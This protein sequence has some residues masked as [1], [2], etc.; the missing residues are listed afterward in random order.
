MNL[1]IGI[2]GTRGIPNHYGGFEQ[3]AEHLSVGLSQR[4]HHVSVYN[5][6]THPYQQENY[7]NVQIIHC[8]DPERLLGTAGQ[9]I[10]DL[11]CILDARKR[12]FDVILQLGYTSS[13][14]WGNL[15]PKKAINITNMDG[16]EWR[17]SKYT[18][19]VQKFLKYAESLAIKH[20]DFLIADSIEIQRY[21]QLK[22]KVNIQYI[23]YG[24]ELFN[25]T[26]EKVLA[27]YK[28]K[29][30]EFSLLMARMEPENNIE[31]I[32]EGV[33]HGNSEKKFVVIGDIAN[34]FGRYIVQKF[35]QDERIQFLGSLFN[36]HKLH[37][38][39][40][41]SQL[42]FHGHSVGGTNPSLLEAMSSR[43]LIAAHDNPFNK[44]ILA[45]DALYFSNAN[46]VKKIL[47]TTKRG[48][49]EEQMI[50]NNMYKIST[51]FNWQ[52][53]INEYEEMMLKCYHHS[54]II[55]PI[56]NEKIIFY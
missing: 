53:V 30:R 18:K 44:S 21:L 2:L 43:A 49:Q 7:H 50:Q 16:L 55:N 46:D 37:T 23:P 35:K 15:F 22:Y 20:S 40:A 9:F 51:H 56:S 10:Y 41:C 31:T 24:A 26:N 13:S 54:Q 32:L 45:N 48:T 38:I 27:E 12:N 39:R 4:G 5:S 8:Y 1:R 36:A 47:E 25:Q 28:L 11:N 6:H 17:R 29:K 3:F 42:Y 52:K 33:Y 14:E 34:R 19:P